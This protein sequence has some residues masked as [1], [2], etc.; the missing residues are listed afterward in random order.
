MENDRLNT[1][2]LLANDKPPVMKHQAR[3]HLSNSPI[4]LGVRP[5]RYSKQRHEWAKILNRAVIICLRNGTLYYYY[6]KTVD[7]N[8]GFGPVNN[9]FPL[10]PVEFGA[11]FVI[12]KER[13][14]T[15]VSRQFTVEGRKPQCLLFDDHGNQIE[16]P[17]E[18]SKT[19]KGWE[20]NVKLNDW[21]QIAVI[22]L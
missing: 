8:G 4:I 12:G 10:T 19:A 22:K 18:P 21:N 6:G 9:M 17:F 5:P 7:S 3:C 20:I 1:F 16:C 2:M 11:G 13:I 15:C 14:I